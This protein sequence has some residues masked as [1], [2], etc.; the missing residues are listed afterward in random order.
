MIAPGTVNTNCNEKTNPIAVSPTPKKDLISGASRVTSTN[1]YP[2]CIHA[3][4]AAKRITNVVNLVTSLD[5]FIITIF[6][7]LIKY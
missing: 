1:E 6:D 2:S 7:Y 5:L 4:N 3:I